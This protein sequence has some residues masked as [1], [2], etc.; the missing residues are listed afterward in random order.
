MI[1]FTEGIYTFYVYILTNKRKTYY[2]QV[3]QVIFTKDYFNIQPNKTKIVLQQS[4][5]WRFQFIT[6]SLDGFNRLSKGK[7]KLKIFPEAK[8]WN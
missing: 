8:K 7:K 2:I 3:L 4:I 1:E 6:K 5:T